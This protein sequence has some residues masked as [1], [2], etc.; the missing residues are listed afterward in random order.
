MVRAE[1][2]RAIDR[3]CMVAVDFWFGLVDWMGEKQKWLEW[4]NAVEG[5]GV[6]LGLTE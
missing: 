6:M 2:R 4:G 5:G 1:T 3:R